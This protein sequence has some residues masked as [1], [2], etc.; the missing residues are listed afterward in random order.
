M[1]LTFMGFGLLAT[2]AAAV[3]EVSTSV[4]SRA[5]DPLQQRDQQLPAKHGKRLRG[6]TKTSGP[7]PLLFEDGDH[8]YISGNYSFSETVAANSTYTNANGTQQPEPRVFFLFLTLT[9][10]KRPE[11]WQAFFNG[12]PANRWRILLHCKHTHICS[13]DLSAGNIL[14]ITQVAT[15]PSEYCRDLVSPMVQ[16]LQT[17]ILESYSP[18]D[19]FVFL[20]E[21]TLPVKP[22]WDI[23]NTLTWD[24]N[25]DF[26]VYPTDH[27]TELQLAQNMR[28]LIV[29]HSQWVVLNHHHAHVMVQNWNTVK[30]EMQ[31]AAWSVPVYHAPK[32]GPWGKITNP[33][34][35]LP[36][37]MCIDEWA[38]FATIFGAF[39]DNGQW[40]IPQDGLPGFGAPPLQL[41]GGAHLTTTFQ[42][43]CRTFAFWDASEFGGS[44]LVNEIAQDW[45]WTK[46][47]CFPRCDSTHPAEFGA[48]S[49]R[50]VTA[51]RR[52]RY[53][54]ARKFADHT[55]TI[56]QFQRIILPA[57]VP[58]LASR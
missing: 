43:I 31:G 40:S 48:L 53:L 9:G 24:T 13:M 26:C 10:I 50:G 1:A 20:S 55:M 34:G 41:R 36:L 30:S 15:V 8:T 6:K 44:N 21:T 17:A 56:D 7:A 58:P 3:G 23:Y 18:Q 35:V 46:L 2:I 14:G 57:A 12:Q 11:L 51:L 54:F 42:G 29:K 49:D 45:P 47:S 25:S 28:A 38:F 19:K 33:A 22:F 4:V 37:P 52:S 16:L 39:V 5:A 32:K 27:W